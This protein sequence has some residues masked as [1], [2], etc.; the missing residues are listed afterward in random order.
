MPAFLYRLLSASKTRYKRK[1][2][3]E[4]VTIAVN[5][6]LSQA[7]KVRPSWWYALIG[8][9][10]ILAGS[11]LFAYFLFQGLSRITDS[12][13][14]VVVPG[15]AELSLSTPATYTIFLEE[16]SVVDGRI[17]STTGSVDGLR[18][19]VTMQPGNQQIFLRRASMS[20]SYKLNDRSGR[21]VLEFPVRV[22]GRYDL[23]CEY[24]QDTK[25][26]QTV[27]AVG[28]GVIGKIFRTV[29]ESLISIF[30]GL[31]SGALVI[32][33]ISIKRKAAKKTLAAY[34]S[35]TP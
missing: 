13:T 7:S 25:G 6:T 34:A 20:A 10:L 12:L 3:V 9:A 5:Q 27:V 21:S 8:L 24:P 1:Y 4:S 18:F 23:S 28:T 29:L 16:Q 11:G 26:P 22:A 15:H 19:S 33:L 14:Q 30:G 2:F 17:Y 31:G 35:Q 32:A